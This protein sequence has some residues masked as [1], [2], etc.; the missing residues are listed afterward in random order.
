MSIVCERV[1]DFVDPDEFLPQLDCT[2]RPGYAIRKDGTK[3]SHL[4]IDAFCAI[5]GY[6]YR[7]EIASAYCRAFNS[8]RFFSNFIIHL[9]ETEDPGLESWLKGY[10][11]D[12]IRNYFDENA[13]IKA[14]VHPK[15]GDHHIHFGVASNVGHVTLGAI[16]SRK[17]TRG[18]TPRLDLQQS[19]VDGY[20]KDQPWNWC[21][22]TLRV[23]ESWRADEKMNRRLRRTWRS[24]A[25]KG[26]RIPRTPDH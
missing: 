9:G 19:W 12:L 17:S 14:V 3:V 10:V 13:I 15:D 8:R 26:Q 11:R 6:H 7:R 23:D 18:R 2:C 1:D 25:E 5:H 22:Y 20:R 24:R 21:A 4:R 16:L